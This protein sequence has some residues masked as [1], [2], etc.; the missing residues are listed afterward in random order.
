MLPSRK[1]LWNQEELH[2]LVI[3]PIEEADWPTAFHWIKR[4]LSS[5]FEKNAEYSRL[6]QSKGEYK[7]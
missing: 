7:L 6:F 2:Q 4:G 3:P 5:P 1:T